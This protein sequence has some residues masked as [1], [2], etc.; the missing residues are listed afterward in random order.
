VGALLWD[1]F[2]VPFMGRALIALAIVGLAGAAVSMFVLLRR[3]AFAAD[4][5][6]HTVFPGVVVGYLAAGQSGVLW[7]ALG[8]AVVTAIALTV[9]TRTARVTHDAAMAILLTAM[10]SVGVVLVSRRASYTADLTAFLFGR[11]LTVSADEIAQT[12]IV[13]GVALL[14]LALTA[15]EQLFRAF[16]PAGARAAGYRVA[17][18]DLAGNVAVALV[19]VAAVRAVGVLLVIAFLVVPAAAGRMVSARLGMI[20]VVGGT[21]VL[22]AA[23]VGLLASYHAS[24][25]YGVRLAAGPTVVLVLTVGYTLL[26]VSAWVRHVVRRRNVPISAALVPASGV[27]GPAPGGVA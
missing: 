17:W 13:A 18:L 4:T 24:V 20:A 8:A 10:F 7:G 16:D 5:L 6:T 1:P 26:S 19:V 12:A 23:Y 11:V 9:L 21:V 15:K 25:T 2:M 22:L 27:S 14:M 3:L